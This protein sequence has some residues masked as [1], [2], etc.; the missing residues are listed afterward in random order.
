MKTKTMPSEEKA[1]F[2]GGSVLFGLIQISC[3]A[4]F[5]L[6]AFKISLLRF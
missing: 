4:K 1:T 3:L 6:S 2:V 5:G